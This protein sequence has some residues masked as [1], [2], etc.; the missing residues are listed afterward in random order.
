MMELLKN[1]MRATVE[2]HGLDEM[3]MY[4]IRIVIADGEDVSASTIYYTRTIYTITVLQL[5]LLVTL[6]TNLTVR[7]VSHTTRYYS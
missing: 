6:H 5:D 7:S 3:D 1:S 2:F 4:P